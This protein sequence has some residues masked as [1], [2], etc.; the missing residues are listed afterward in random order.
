[1]T[2]V[3]RRE[4]LYGLGAALGA[5]ALTDLCAHERQNELPFASRAGTH[6]PAAKAV[7]MGAH[8]TYKVD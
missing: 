1:M 7:I 6:R 4:A 3:S 8:V 5:R 2:R